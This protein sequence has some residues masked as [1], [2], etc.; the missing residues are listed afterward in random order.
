[1]AQT[2]NYKLDKNHT[3]VVNMFDDFERYSK[4]PDEYTP[5]PPKLFEPE[6]PYV[7]RCE[8]Q[9]DGTLALSGSWL[10]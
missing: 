10:C 8:L 6:V 5:P 9:P 3:F 2:N 1:M 7:G 4:V